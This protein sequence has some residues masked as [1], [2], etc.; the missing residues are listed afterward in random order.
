[1]EHT[2]GV[3]PGADKR[4]DERFGFSAAEPEPSGGI[5]GGNQDGAGE[6]R[7]AHGRVETLGR[8]GCD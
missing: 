1:M 6:G 5:G 2:L 7:G 4:G 8:K 3:R